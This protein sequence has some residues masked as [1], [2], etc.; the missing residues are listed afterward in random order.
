M[1]DLSHLSRVLV[2]ED[3]ALIALDMEATLRD[4]GV[5]EIVAAVSVDEALLAI[6]NG[7]LH[8]AVLD[9][10]LGRNGWSYDIAYR[11]EARGIP[12][13]FSSGSADI[14]EDFRHVPMVKKPFSADQLLAALALATR[15]D[16]GQAAE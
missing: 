16:A 11:L 13:V 4:A 7:D 8:G 1:A 15:H 2:V 12:F 5:A 3:E 14:A 6:D 9:L 10:H